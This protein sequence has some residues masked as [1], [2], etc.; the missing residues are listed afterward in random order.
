MSAYDSAQV[1]C[2]SGT[3]GSSFRLGLLWTVAVSSSSGDA[4]LTSD[5]VGGAF[6]ADAVA[7]LHRHWRP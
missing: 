4:Y 3:S 5:S 2:S 6:V 7:W 1:D